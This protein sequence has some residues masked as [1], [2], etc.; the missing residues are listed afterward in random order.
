MTYREPTAKGYT[1]K[2]EFEAPEA[3]IPQAFPEFEIAVEEIFG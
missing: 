2:A 1:S 3:V